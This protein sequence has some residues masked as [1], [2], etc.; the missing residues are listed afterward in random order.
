MNK[1]EANKSVCYTPRQ[2]VTALAVACITATLNPRFRHPKLRPYRAAMYSGL[3]LSAI[4][5]IIHG[6]LI[7]GWEIQNSKMS[8][9]WMGLMGALNLTGAA[10]YAARVGCSNPFELH[11]LTSFRFRNDGILEDTIYMVAAIRYSM[12]R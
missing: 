6:L 7:H 10:A 9:R 3:G 11:A 4:V 8:L 1:A 5:F 2:Q 12:L